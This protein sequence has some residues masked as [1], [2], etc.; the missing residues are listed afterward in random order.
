MEEKWS[1][2][3]R[4][5]LENAGSVGGARIELYVERSRMITF[6]IEN[7]LDCSYT[8]RFCL[9]KVL[10]AVLS[11]LHPTYTWVFFFG[12]RPSTGYLPPDD[13]ELGPW[14]GMK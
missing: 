9:R 4:V 11:S 2:L 13:F 7:Q 3:G 14:N 5:G 6:C 12:T 10:T 8:L 1:V